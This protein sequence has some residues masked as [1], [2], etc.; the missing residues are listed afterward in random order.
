MHTALLYFN[1]SIRV[2]VSDERDARRS[3]Y[4]SLQS[5]PTLKD[6]AHEW[7]NDAQGGS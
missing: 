3:V 4:E 6:D 7:E 5:E 2:G 1:Y